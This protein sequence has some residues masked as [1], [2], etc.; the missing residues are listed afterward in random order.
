MSAPDVALWSSD[1]AVHATGGVS[2]TAW[3][4]KG[5]SIDSRTV[6]QNDLFVAIQGPNQDGHKYVSSAIKKG[7]SAA[8]IHEDIPDLEGAVLRVADTLEGLNALARAARARTSARIVAVTGSVGKTSTKEALR[9]ALAPSGPTH[10][11]AASYNNNW[12]VPLS[13]ARMPAESA[14][15]VFEVGMNHAGEIAPLVGMVKPHVAIVTTVQP[16]HIE[17]FPN[18]DAIADE[19]ADIFSAMEG[20]GTAI[21]NVDIPQYDRIASKAKNFGVTNIIGFGERSDA[22]AHLI[23]SEANDLGSDVEASVLGQQI[24]YRVG[25]PGHHFVL[26]SLAVLAAV[27]ELGGNLDAATMA[28]S[29]LQATVGRGKRHEIQL[30]GGKILLIDESYNANPASVAAALNV[31]SNTSPGNGGRRIAVLGDMLELGEKSQ[32]L[33]AD[34]S[35]HIADQNIDQAFLCGE[36]MFALWNALPEGVRGGY[37]HTSEE[38]ISEIGD[39]INAGDVVMVKGSL[40]SQMGIIVQHFFARNENTKTTGGR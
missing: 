18:V 23:R 1:E 28:L 11:S 38:L 24:R 19:K 25:V 27:K 29:Q 8:L 30:D 22:Q 13:L 20:N 21:I 39:Q 14:F 34:L 40:G 15:G 37:A 12:G 5:V 32:G 2:S 33:H 26:N 3:T 35:K 4:A 9:V 17:F 7:A 6:A 31:L 16:V 36:H 10:A